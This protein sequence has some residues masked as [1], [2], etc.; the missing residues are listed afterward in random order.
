VIGISHGVAGQFQR[1]PQREI[2]VVDQDPDQLGNRQ[3]RM[4]VVELDRGRAGQ[5]G[6]GAVD[7][8][9]PPDQILQ[10]GGDEE[11]FLLQPQFLA[12]R[13]RIVGIEHA[14][15]V[16]CLHLLGEGV[17][18]LTA[19]EFLEL[20]RCRRARRPE[21]ERIA[22]VAPPAR[23]RR[24]VGDGDHMLRRPPGEFLPV[25]A[26]RLDAPTKADVISDLRP[27]ELPGIAELQP[28]LRALGLPAVAHH[29]AEQAMVVADAVAEAGEAHRRHALHVAG[30]E[31][32]QAAIAERRVGFDI[33]DRI[34]ADAELG[35]GRARGG[36]QAQIAGGVDQQPPDQ[37]FQ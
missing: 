24:V 31:P 34:E 7:A 22:A 8:Q 10:R 17:E 2:V 21:P 35:Q 30:G 5:G 29:L 36:D 11:V 9:M 6:D 3:R 14:R 25:I 18:I 23:D 4:R 33:P 13:R 26:A 20:H 1:G 37:E 12:G 28:V 27:L 15:D 32:S 16:G 19:V